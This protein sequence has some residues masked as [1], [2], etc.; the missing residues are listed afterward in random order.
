MKILVLAGVLLVFCLSIQ[1]V[2]S[3]TGGLDL[4]RRIMGRRS[5][6]PERS[7]TGGLDLG[8]RMVG[9]RS[10]DP[11]RIRRSPGPQLSETISQLLLDWHQKVGLIQ[12]VAAAT[13]A[14]KLFHTLINDISYTCFSPAPARGRRRRRYNCN[15]R[16]CRGGKEANGGWLYGYDCPKKCWKKEHLHMAGR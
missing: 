6:D 5:A 16:S 13:F 9:K 10:A 7:Q 8:R 3:Q 4:G 15:T 1:S 14:K 11:E 2:Q 12:F